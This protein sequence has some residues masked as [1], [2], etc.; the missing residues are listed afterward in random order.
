MGSD[1]VT[2]YRREEWSVRRVVHEKGE[3][4]IDQIAY[5]AGYSNI[6]L[7]FEQINNFNAAITNMKKISAP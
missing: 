7:F 4:A 6:A 2:G 3:I 1:E 5:P